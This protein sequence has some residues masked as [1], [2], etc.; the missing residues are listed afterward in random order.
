MCKEVKKNQNLKKNV[1][2]KGKMRVIML[3]VSKS[4]NAYFSHT[5]YGYVTIFYRDTILNT[6]IVYFNLI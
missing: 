1:S 6:D 2:F 3:D 4:I 5:I